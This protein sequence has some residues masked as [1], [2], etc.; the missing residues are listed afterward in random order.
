MIPTTVSHYEILEKLGEG[1]MGMVYKARDKKLDR[2]VALKFLSRH[3]SLEEE[4]KKRF[5]Q[6]AKAASALDHPHICT[7]F[8]ISD[9][10]ED[11]LFISMGFYEGETLHRK[12]ESGPLPIEEAV[13]IARQ[14]ADG[15]AI[16][17]KRQIVH[18]DI[19]PANIMVTKEQGV[20]I[21]DFG[22][23]K[24]GG[25]SRITDHNVSLGTP[26]Y[27]SLEQTYGSDV[28]HKTDI[29][30][31]GVV[32]Y[33]MLTGQLPFQGEYEQAV[34]YAIIN[35]RPKPMQ[36][37]RSEIPET[38]IPIIEKML[39]KYPADRFDSM[40][41][42]IEQLRCLQESAHLSRNGITR[43][44][45]SKYR[46]AVLPFTNISPEKA[47]EYFAYGLTEEFISALSKIAELR[48]IARASVMQYKNMTKSIKEIGKELNVCFVLEGS[49]R[50]VAN[51]VRIS[52][53]LIDAIS[54]E[55]IWSREYDRQFED[56]FALQSDIAQ[57]VADALKVQLLS[58]EKQRMTSHATKNME[59]YQLYLKGRFYW[60]KRTEEGLKKCIELL[61]RAIGEDPGYALAYSGI[62][63]AYIVL[64]D[65]GYL[66]HGDAYTKAKAAAQKALAFD[67]TLAEAHTSLACVK[68]LYDWDWT[69]ADHEFRKALALD[70]KYATTYHWYAIN[71]L[72]P[73]GEFDEAMSCIHHAQELDP[74][75]LI[76]N[77]TV[78]LVHYFARHFDQ[79][80]EKCLETIDMDPSFGVAYFFL[81]WAYDQVGHYGEAIKSL[82]KAISLSGSVSALLA[83]LGCVYASSGDT[84][85][86]R[87]IL[88][89][90][91]SQTEPN[92]ISPYVMYSIAAVYTVLNESEQALQWLHRAHD[93]RSYRL[94]YLRVDPK[95]D[96]LRSE[97]AFQRLLSAVG[98][99]AS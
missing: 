93:A 91:L 51:Q 56:I 88:E 82:Q 95:F 68:S 46:F 30:S 59:A 54:E 34:I 48:V 39:A 41:E 12:L 73:N 96:R 14:I 69:G 72:T 50:K 86:A 42:I 11:Q 22:L 36:P 94:I 75:S 38:L 77:T 64:G 81:G 25:K 23:A 44:G 27:M 47:D 85:S 45:D 57:R 15:L 13:E 24:L 99:S 21:L 6:E 49:V 20:K 52:A 26:A 87:G 78:A 40:E 18:R 98:L 29:W 10:E 7:I 74:L 92:E 89:E 61:Q 33:E 17:H 37:I 90:L 31:L 84:E 63:D 83:E 2:Y 32:F 65:Y 43:I 79:A 58:D 16:A 3:L 1:G 80:I 66:P 60:N 97:P 53:Q 5:I 28:T 9:T 55:L 4:E 67:D 8:E 76:I 70:P 19:K 71:Y 35:L 62:A